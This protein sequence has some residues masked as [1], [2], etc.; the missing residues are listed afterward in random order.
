MFQ[1]FNEQFTINK[2]TTLNNNTQQQT[3]KTKRKR[4][5]QTYNIKRTTHNVK[6]K[7]NKTSK[8]HLNHNIK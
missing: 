4:E 7:Q 8:T 3:R 6:F 1:D 2:Q 5:L